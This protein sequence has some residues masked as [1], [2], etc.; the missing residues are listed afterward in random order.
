MDVLKLN[1]TTFKAEDLCETYTSL[2]WT[3]RYLSPGEF[4]LKT[5]EVVKVSQ[6]F[7]VGSLIAIRESPEIM[8]VETLLIEPDGNTGVPELTLTGRSFSSFLENRVLT[9]A[10]YG[11]PYEKTRVMS[12]SVF[13]AILIWNS[14]ANNS[15]ENVTRSVSIFFDR[16][17]LI[18]DAL[19]AVPNLVVS[20]QDLIPEVQQNWLK[21]NWTILEAVEQIQNEYLIG[22]RAIRPYSVV[23]S[24]S[25]ISFDTSRTANRGLQIVEAS[26]DN[27]KLRLDVY[28]GLNRTVKQT[29][30]QPV[31]FQSLTGDLVNQRLLISNKTKKDYAFIISSEGDLIVSKY[32]TENDFGLNRRVMLIDGGSKPD[33]MLYPDLW[34]LNTRQKFQPTLKA[35][36]DIFLVESESSPN[37]SY[38][39]GEDYFLGDKITFSSDYAKEMSM[40]VN[41]IIRTEDENGENLSVGFTL[42]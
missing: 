1:S 17:D 30:V 21:D 32:L 20:I 13:I 14:L 42:V 40:L 22:V 34:K 19:L 2:V 25:R 24:Y 36:K 23:D 7:P 26:S 10:F 27:T 15:A 31:I 18:Q 11:T 35:A 37:N 28:R 39:Y 41:E 33:D 3:E 9:E 8:F 12:P 6:M 16:D 38:V 4:V 29:L 5:P